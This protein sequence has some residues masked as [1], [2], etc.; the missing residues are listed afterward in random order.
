MQETNTLF[1]GQVL[2]KMLA[3]DH[4]HSVVGE[5]ECLPEI[6]A[7]VGIHG[8]VD[9]D[10]TRFSVRPTPNMKHA[11]QLHRRGL[12]H[13]APVRTHDAPLSHNLTERGSKSPGG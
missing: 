6:Q 3:V 8:E 13:S 11:W 5:W 4:I 2:E 12:T 9:V 10:P 7:K 1:K